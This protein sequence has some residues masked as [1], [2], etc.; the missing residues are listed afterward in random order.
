VA[1]KLAEDQVPL[2]DL[3]FVSTERAGIDAD[4][5]LFGAPD[6]VVEVPSPGTAK[7]DREV[8]RKRYL[9]HGVTEVWLVD[10]DRR[11]VEVFRAEALPV[12]HRDIFP[13]RVGGRMF[14]L[15]LAKVFPPG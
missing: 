9:E 14:E 12:T 3:V 10:P 8:K 13:W 6:L 15:P 11:E 2:P 7:F 5:A 4:E 1:V